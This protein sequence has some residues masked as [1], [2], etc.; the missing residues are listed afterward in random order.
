MKKY[1]S[2]KLSKIIKELHGFNFESDVEYPRNNYGDYST[3][4]PM[5]LS[6]Q[7][8]KN[9]K[10]IAAEIITKIK[11]DKE[12]S[13][14]FS[15]VEQI[16]GFINFKL[17]EKALEEELEKILSEKNHYGDSDIGRHQKTMIEFVS[18]NP[19]GPL[20][21]A[22]GRGGFLGD[23]LANILKKAGY[24][25]H[26]EYYVNDI[27]N[28]IEILAESVARRVLQIKGQDVE[29]PDYCY[30]GEYIKDI[31][32]EF[33]G[34]VKAEY[35]SIG[36]IAEA[37]KKYSM[38]K[39]VDMIRKDLEDAG[40]FYD[41]WFFESELYSKAWYQTK[42]EIDKALYLLDKE[43]L[44]EEKEGAI[45]FQSSHFGD[46]KDR[47][48][49]K[50]TG[51]KTYFASDIAYY[52]NRAKR[53]FK[54]IIMPLGA[55]HHGYIPRM[56]SII[57]ALKRDVGID[58][59]IFQMVNLIQSGKVKR[60]SK[61]KGSF[62]LLSE[63]INEVGKDALRFFFLMYDP[64]THMDFDL[65][66]AKEKSQ[67]NPVYYVQYAYAR[68]SSILKK[69][70]QEGRKSGKAL[71]KHESF[72]LE[73]AEASLIKKLMQ[74]PELIEEISKTYEAN[75]L[76]HYSIDLAKEFHNFY[77]KCRVISDDKNLTSSR[78]RIIMGVKIV[79]GETL[80]LMGV[81]A[82]EKM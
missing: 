48:V 56:K 35:S 11:S 54:K 82:P 44:L 33:I 42:S 8:K 78:L 69:A 9:P 79:L 20:T 13:D 46:E 58:F 75:K 38:M 29:F 65:D 55:D 71:E 22:N 4:A 45:W 12:M 15:N 25:T 73:E 61:R 59:L 62:V 23:A 7:L 1:L 30:Q 67:K 64:N 24:N 63:I 21:M 52:E 41:R 37:V 60:M 72:F 47:V 10:D 49:V 19:T 36:D 70:E 57:K 40:I 80:R 34:K 26:K 68:I 53:K 18:A 66:L 5:K 81:S 76:A 32:R 16:N 77:E 28:Q 39:M 14:I 51:E 74:M 50:E 31:A 27:G 6:K 3:S 17:S 2:K 43:N